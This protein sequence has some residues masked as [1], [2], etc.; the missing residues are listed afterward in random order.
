MV[1]SGEQVPQSA[2]MSRHLTKAWMV[3]RECL[4]RLALT[5][6]YETD[7]MKLA[8]QTRE[9]EWTWKVG[10]RLVGRATRDPSL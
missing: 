4:I 5:L 8:Q 3:R 6:G 10:L 2:Q 7:G 9:R 1:L